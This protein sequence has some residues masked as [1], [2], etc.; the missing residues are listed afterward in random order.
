VPLIKNPDL[1]DE[2]LEETEELIEIF[3][4]SLKTAEKKR[5]A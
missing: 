4:A 5:R 1:L 3:V 2:I